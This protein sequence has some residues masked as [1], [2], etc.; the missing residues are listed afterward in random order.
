MKTTTDISYSA[1]WFTPSFGTT[2]IACHGAEAGA[3]GESL[4]EDMFS[5]RTRGG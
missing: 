5:K 4:N 1:R 2:C 3:L